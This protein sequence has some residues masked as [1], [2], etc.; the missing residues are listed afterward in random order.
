MARPAERPGPI[1][2][3]PHDRAME[4]RDE[5]DVDAPEGTM[6]EDQCGH[7]E[8]LRLP[9]GCGL[10][11]DRQAEI[12]MRVVLAEIDFI[13]IPFENPEDIYPV[14][15]CGLEIGRSLEAEGPHE[16]LPIE[17]PPAV[18]YCRRTRYA[19]CSD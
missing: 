3:P 4:R 5:G 10:L 14:A 2:R 7:R 11:E 1:K 6:A 13:L 19:L 15:A 16:P 17:R 12:E 18:Q 8:S 9:R